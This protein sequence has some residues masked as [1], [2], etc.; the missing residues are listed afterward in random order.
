MTG[1][2]TCDRG[3]TAASLVVQ[4]A[5]QTQNIDKFQD[6]FSRNSICLF[7]GIFYLKFAF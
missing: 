5:M 1:L 6:F 4:T 3:L 2:E 7:Q